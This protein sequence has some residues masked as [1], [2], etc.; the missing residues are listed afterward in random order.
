MCA[1][2]GGGGHPERNILT[3]YSFTFCC[4]AQVLNTGCTHFRPELYHCVKVCVANL[5]TSFQVCVKR[6]QDFTQ[7]GASRG[8]SNEKPNSA[9]QWISCPLFPRPL[10]HQH[11][12]SAEASGQLQVAHVPQD[13][14]SVQVFS[15]L[16]SQK[17]SVGWFAFLSDWRSVLL[18]HTK[19][20]AL[21]LQS[22]GSDIFTK[23]PSL[24]FE[25]SGFGIKTVGSALQ[26]AVRW[27]KVFFPPQGS[28]FYQ[29]CCVI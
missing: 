14:A 29:F 25:D 4:F 26:G 19:L 27:E 5:R 28:D 18:E 7:E 6:L 11:P 12:N 9:L 2:A 16:L 22:C 8:A 1:R 10:G 15:S 21:R 3:F 13:C 20:Q 24:Q 23:T 17:Q